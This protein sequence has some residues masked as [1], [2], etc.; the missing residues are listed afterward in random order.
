MET[1]SNQRAK[2]WVGEDATRELWI[3]AFVVYREE[4][5]EEVEGPA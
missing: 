5:A 1:G 4:M 2:A 3:P